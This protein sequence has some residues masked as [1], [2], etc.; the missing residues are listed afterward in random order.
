MPASVI[1]TAVTSIDYPDIFSAFYEQQP[2]H[3]EAPEQISSN[4]Q[5]AT[6]ETVCQHA[7]YRAD[8]ESRQQLQDQQRGLLLCLNR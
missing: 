3:N 6:I 8:E 1:S 2:K 5:S 7:R 4:H